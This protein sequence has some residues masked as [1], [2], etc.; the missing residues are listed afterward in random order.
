MANGSSRIT[1]GWLL[2]IMFFGISALMFA[3]ISD[4]DT[5]VGRDSDGDGV[6]DG[7]DEDPFDG[8]YD[9]DYCEDGRDTSIEAG[10]CC[11]VLGILSLLIVQSGTKAKKNAPQLIYIPQVQQPAPQQVIHHHT[12]HTY[13]PQPVQTPVQPIVNPNPAPIQQAI[14]DIKQAVTGSS[15]V[16][17]WNQE[18][19]NLEL[20]RD[21]EGA[22]EAYQK[23]GM[24]AEA[25]RV[26]Q[27]HL[28]NNDPQ[29]KIDIAQLGD[30]IQDSVVMKDG[31]SQNDEHQV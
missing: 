1:L 12:T 8:W 14:Q 21:W 29:V 7:C 13:A 30:K 25:G 23:A 6:D 11:C 28:E 2:A 22:A 17:D 27:M 26:R 16:K 10:S 20:A 19:Q 9:T 5:S 15:G 31:Q 4:E 18:A 3:T 24:Y